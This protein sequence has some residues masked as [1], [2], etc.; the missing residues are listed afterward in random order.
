MFC[1]D[2]LKGLPTTPLAEGGQKRVIPLLHLRGLQKKK[3]IQRKKDQR[4][5]LGKEAKTKRYSSRSISWN[6]ISIRDLE[7]F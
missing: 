6:E 1:R 4:L 5:K 3:K 2:V 7:N